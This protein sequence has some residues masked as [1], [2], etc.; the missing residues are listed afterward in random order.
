[1]KTKSEKEYASDGID[2]S[3]EV[4]GLVNGL[5]TQCSLPDVAGPFAISPTVHCC[6]A[7]ACRRSSHQRITRPSIF[8]SDM[9]RIVVARRVTSYIQHVIMPC[10]GWASLSVIYG[11]DKDLDDLC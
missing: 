9:F 4:F 7:T 11:V 1:M 3:K 5:S 10:T 6:R 8:S 2:V